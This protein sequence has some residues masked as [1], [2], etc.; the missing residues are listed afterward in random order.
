MRSEWVK[1]LFMKTCF[2]AGGHRH[3]IHQQL[4]ELLAGT[5]ISEM[6]DRVERAHDKKSCNDLYRR[7]LWDYIRSVHQVTHNH[8]GVEYKV[9][10]VCGS[11][12]CVLVKDFF[13]LQLIEN[14]LNSMIS[15][16]ELSISLAKCPPLLSR[17]AAVHVAYHH[18]QRE[19]LW[20]GCLTAQLPGVLMML[21][22]VPHNPDRMELQLHA[23]QV[24]L[25]DNLT[26]PLEASDRE[27]L[28][29]W[30]VWMQLCQNA[31]DSILML[32]KET[33]GLAAAVL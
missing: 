15:S 13:L 16:P 24:V 23:V 9:S 4:C 25:D 5:E 28:P 27:H 18:C 29:Q 22:D 26:P 1:D 32:R 14:A 8:S 7:Y 17:I 12:V 2:S 20:F 33:E 19:L 30:L 3:Q 6:L 11:G 10:C 31:I 21:Q